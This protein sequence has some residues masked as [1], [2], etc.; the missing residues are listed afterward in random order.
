VAEERKWDDQRVEAIIGGLLRAGV[1]LS[2]FVV[3]CGA[4]VYLVRHGESPADYSV[5]HGEP[6]ALKSVAGILRYTFAFRGRG[7]IQLG[8]LLLIATP[9]ARVAFSVFAFA[10]ER[11]WMYASFSFLVLAILLYSLF[12]SSMII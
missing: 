9:V 5:F 8:L 11:D 1:L 2:A 10:G 12:G 4:A 6:N 7:M 3:L